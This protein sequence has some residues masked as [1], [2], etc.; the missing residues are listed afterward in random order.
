MKTISKGLINNALMFMASF[1]TSV[2]IAFIT[3]V[4]VDEKFIPL[5]PNLL[6]ISVGMLIIG[7]FNIALAIYFWCK[8]FDEDYFTKEEIDEQDI[9]NT[10]EDTEES[11]ILLEKPITPS[12]HP[13]KMSLYELFINCRLYAGLNSKPRFDFY[14]KD[15]HSIGCLKYEQIGSIKAALLSEPVSVIW[16]VLTESSLLTVITVSFLNLTAE[17]ITTLN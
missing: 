8:I 15:G 17:E 13:L 7:V 10:K 5:K 14:D 12:I 4:C 16:T 3:L 2:G 1:I 9:P 6:P 11:S